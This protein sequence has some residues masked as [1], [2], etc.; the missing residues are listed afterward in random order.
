M[1]IVIVHSHGR[2]IRLVFGSKSEQQAAAALLGGY[3]LVVN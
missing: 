3:T 1:F 2:K